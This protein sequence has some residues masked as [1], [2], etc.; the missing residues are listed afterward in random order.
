MIT[1]IDCVADVFIGPEST[2]LLEAAHLRRRVA[3]WQEASASIFEVFLAVGDA[4]FLRSSCA[5][6]LEMMGWRGR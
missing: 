1:D 2:G 4:R 5:S 6:V 3:L